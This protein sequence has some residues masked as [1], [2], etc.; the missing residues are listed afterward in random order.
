MLFKSQEGQTAVFVEERKVQPK[1]PGKNPFTI[2]KLADPVS[3]ESIEVYKSRNYEG[4]SPNR[5]DK[6]RVTINLYQNRFTAAE[7]VNMTIL[8]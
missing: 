6:I 3:Y 2:L 4:D 1:D 8:K 5:G 7:V